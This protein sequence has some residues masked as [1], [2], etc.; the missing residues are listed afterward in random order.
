MNRLA[1]T[2]VLMILTSPLV[3]AGGN[4]PVKPPT[5]AEQYAALKKE[6]DS[7]PRTS[8]PTN[9]DERLKYL[10]RMYKHHNAVA[11]KLLELAEKYPKDPITLDALILAVSQVN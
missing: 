6:Y 7:P 8:V 10:G 11:L 5:A 4:D 9:D 1:S 2:I 3:V